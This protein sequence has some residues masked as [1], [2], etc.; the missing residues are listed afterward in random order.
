MVVVVVV[1]MLLIIRLA[2]PSLMLSTAYVLLM[3]P[4]WGHVAL[5]ATSMLMMVVS[6]TAFVARLILLGGIRI[7][8]VKSQLLVIALIPVI[9]I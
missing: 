8:M 1:V 4:M 3:M 9:V 6:G 2:M 7:T 5:V